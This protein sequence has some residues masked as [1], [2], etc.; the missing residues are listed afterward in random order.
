[1]DA[2]VAEKEVL[3]AAAAE[4]ASQASKSAAA[5][6]RVREL[7]AEL[8]KN[9][10]VA[11]QL[12]GLVRASEEQ[13]SKQAEELDSVRAELEKMTDILKR[14]RMKRIEAEVGQDEGSQGDR[15][16]RELRMD[17]GEFDED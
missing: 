4:G 5:G 12:E 11:S 2:L 9:Q 7:E 15:I 8:G 10:E 13:R 1:M 3:T 16:L 17:L 14:E 6:D